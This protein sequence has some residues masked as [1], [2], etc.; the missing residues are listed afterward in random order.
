VSVTGRIEKDAPNI[1]HADFANMYVGGGVLST[2][3]VQ[4]EML[5]AL[6]PELIVSRLL[7][8][9]L[10]DNETLVITG[11]QRFS[12]YVGYGRSFRWNGDYVDSTGSDAWG[13]HTTQ[14]VAMDALV[15]IKKCWCRHCRRSH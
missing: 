7:T 1:L 4:E 3:C 12:D 2:G 6:C 13:R 10:D 11:Y 5:F 15:I 8:E 9:V 14:L